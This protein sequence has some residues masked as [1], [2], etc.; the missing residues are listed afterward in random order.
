MRRTGLLVGLGLALASG[1]LEAEEPGEA[2]VV[3]EQIRLDAYDPTGQ[4]ASIAAARGRP[5]LARWGFLT[6]ALVPTLELED[7]TISRRQDDGSVST[8]R[9]PTAT[10]D[11]N[12]KT[13][14]TPSGRTIF[15]TESR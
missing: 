8:E 4:C 13:M 3:V 10:L 2:P 15:S 14:S 12:G 7:V 9:W 5:G 6:T 11:W 1:H